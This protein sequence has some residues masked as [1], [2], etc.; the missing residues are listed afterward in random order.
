MK[1][2]YGREILLHHVQA[3]VST[4]EPLME[5][6]ALHREKFPLL[7]SRI[8]CM[9]IGRMLYG[10][11]TFSLDDRDM[12]SL[13]YITGSE[14]P[15]QWRESYRA[16]LEC[17]QD[18]TQV[19]N[20]ISIDW[21]AD[22]MRRVH[23]NAFRV[24]L[25][26]TPELARDYSAALKR[27]FVQQESEASCGSAIYLVSSLFNHSCTPNV[28][29]SFPYNNHII[30]MKALRDIQK[31]EHLCI[32]YIDSVNLSYEDRQQKLFHGY[33]FQ[34]QCEKCLEERR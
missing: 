10:D 14:I 30:E 5:Y 7:V 9:R 32:S 28:E 19:R 33:G 16:L 25:I 17:F 13:C 20:M 2:R 3:A 15:D 26:N 21:Y 29:P 8:A 34:C 22:M 6:A 11:N 12:E 24:D 1:E 27:M 4:W 31:N 23:P 18:Q